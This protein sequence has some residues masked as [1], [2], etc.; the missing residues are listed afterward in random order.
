MHS[1]LTFF[2]WLI[3]DCLIL[4]RYFRSRAGSLLASLAFHSAAVSAQVLCTPYNH[5]PC[6]FMQSHLR[7]VYV[8]LAVTCHL[9]FWPHD[10]DLLRATA[11]TRVRFHWYVDTE[12]AIKNLHWRKHMFAVP[13]VDMYGNGRRNGIR[14]QKGVPCT[15]PYRTDGIA[16]LSFFPSCIWLVSSRHVVITLVRLE[17]NWLF[18][19]YY[20]PCWNKG[21][22]EPLTCSARYKFSNGY[23][24][25]V[26]RHSVYC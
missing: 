8:C 21:V 13:Y 24:L 18:F 9:H 20:F 4:Q 16:A 25:Y 6:H 15:C 2:G 10:R 7:K 22:D 23:K 11:E 3:N 14:L 12:M 1:N 5:A 17:T 26:E 19:S